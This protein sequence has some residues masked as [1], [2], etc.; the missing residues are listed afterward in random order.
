[1]P[2]SFRPP[3]AR[4]QRLTPYVFALASLKLMLPFFIPGPW[5]FHR[6]ELLYLA[7]GDHLDLLRMQFPP[8]IAL[9]AAT[10]DDGAGGTV[11]GARLAAAIP[12]TLYLVVAA[13]IARDMGGGRRA[14]I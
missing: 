10:I 6:D 14:Q 13:L 2:L 5:E 9:A 4:P 12:S 1:M 8:L 7:M 3:L 11:L